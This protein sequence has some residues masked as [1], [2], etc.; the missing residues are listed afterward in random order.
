MT[1]SAKSPDGR[2]AR[3]NKHNL[4]RRQV[5]L[6]AAIAVVEASEPGA[7]IHVQQIAERAGLNR[8]VVYRHFTDRADL[9]HAILVEIVEGVMERLLP[10]L[11]LD[12]TVP[13]IIH[14][15]VFAYVDW[16]AGHPELHRLVDHASIG[17][18]LEQG[19][20]RVA[21]VIVEVLETALDMLGVELDEDDAAAID[22]LAYALVGAAF[23]SVRRWVSREPRRPD[24]AEFASLLSD[25]V[26]LILNGHAARL[27]VEIDPDLP[28]EELLNIPDPEAAQA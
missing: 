9:D 11:T 3:W 1:A 4:E 5:I 21:S 25:S 20:D 19:L 28:I 18:A 15:M 12:G 17:G 6:D 8:S 23:S 26:W 14:R 22:P 2:Q 7:E 16:A 13:E 27:G 10:A 24:T